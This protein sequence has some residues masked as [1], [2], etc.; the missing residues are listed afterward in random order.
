MISGTLMLVETVTN[1]VLTTNVFARIYTVTTFISDYNNL[2]GK[3]T[4][5][6]CLQEST[7]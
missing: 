1:I 7:R 6:I 5:H 4:F 2:L 3:I